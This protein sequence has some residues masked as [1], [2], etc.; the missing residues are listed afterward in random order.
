MTSKLQSSKV[1]RPFCRRCITT[2]PIRKIHYWGRKPDEILCRQLD[3]AGNPVVIPS[4]ARASI[5][6]NPSF[7]EVPE[8]TIQYNTTQPI[9]STKQHK[10]SGKSIPEGEDK[11]RFSCRQL[12][13]ARVNP[14]VNPS[15]TDPWYYKLLC[16]PGCLLQTRYP[17]GKSA[18]WGED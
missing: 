18:S 16:N 7:T 11:A 12:G 15:F 9:G 2:K 8:S 14:L 17:L 13:R 10:L 6:V 5:L 4:W 1:H 3:R